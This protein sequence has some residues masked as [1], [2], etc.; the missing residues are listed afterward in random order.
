MWQEN[1]FLLDFALVPEILLATDPNIA[2]I[3]GANLEQTTAL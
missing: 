3:K 2:V 1:I